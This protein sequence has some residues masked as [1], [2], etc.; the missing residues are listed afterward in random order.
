MP[1]EPEKHAEPVAM[2]DSVFRNLPS[3]EE[4]AFRRWARAHATPRYLAKAGIY[5]PVVRDEWWRMG[6]RTTGPVA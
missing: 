3:A 1:E 2:P 5:H 6:L 4:E